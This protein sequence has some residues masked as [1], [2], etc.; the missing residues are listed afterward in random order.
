MSGAGKN[1]ERIARIQ[2]K[3]VRDV[4]LTEQELRRRAGRRM[5]RE[6]DRAG[7]GSGTWYDYDRQAWVVD[8]R[9]QGC[10]HRRETFMG[11]WPC[12]C[13]GRLHE[14]ERAP[15][16]HRQA[17]VMTRRESVA[18]TVA[19]I[20]REAWRGGWL[21]QWSHP[22]EVKRMEEEAWILARQ[23]AKE[24]TAAELAS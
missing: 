17:H 4:E 15:T 9:Y 14:G 6:L 8:G 3:I 7:R 24:T 12:Q 19:S 2:E 18:T 16:S 22:A 13:Y 10:G 5:R 23:L 11:R 21:N 1:T 20:M